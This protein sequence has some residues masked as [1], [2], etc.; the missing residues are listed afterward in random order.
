VIYARVLGANTH[1]AAMVTPNVMG[2]FM[3]QHSPNVT[4]T[5]ELVIQ[6]GT[7]AELDSVAPVDD[8][9]Q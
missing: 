8:P 6:V 7:D 2:Q 3:T 5:H 1:V 4:V 9:A